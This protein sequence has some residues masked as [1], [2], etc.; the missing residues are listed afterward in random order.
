MLNG[1][2]AE[3]GFGCSWQLD[4]KTLTPTLSHGERE[5]ERPD[6]R[7]CD[8]PLTCSFWSGGDEEGARVR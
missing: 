7:T 4:R 1:R 5:E 8:A 2:W 6:S 3:I